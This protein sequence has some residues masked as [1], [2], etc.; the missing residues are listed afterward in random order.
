[1]TWWEFP[2]AAICGVIGT[3]LWVTP[4]SKL[5]EVTRSLWQKV[6][7]HE[8]VNTAC[9]PVPPIDKDEARRIRLRIRQVLLDTWD[10]IGIKNE[11]NA[12]DEYDAYI[13]DLY[14][15]LSSKAPDSK[16]AEYLYWVAHNRMG[17]ESARA[18]DTA[19]T[20]EALK[21]IELDLDVKG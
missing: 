3:Y 21:A 11:P 13:G 8:R 20:V 19:N 12:Q 1:M 10:P 18:S 7:K 14:E 9:T 15:L 17:F 2:L 5:T 16:I 6:S 4:S